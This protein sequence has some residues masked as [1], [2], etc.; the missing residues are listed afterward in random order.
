MAKKATIEWKP[1]MKQL[2]K[3]FEHKAKATPADVYQITRNTL[4][5]A[6]NHAFKEARRDTG[7]MRDSFYISLDSDMLGGKLWG[8]ADYT[9]Y[10]E[11]G[12][13]NMPPKPAIR[14]AFLIYRKRYLD[15]L[16]RVVE[17]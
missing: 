7:H 15:D 13:I 14:A 1:E 16:L 17:I 4:A 11:Y 12:T 8:G 5:E 2:I 3:S 10:N 6:H 9:V